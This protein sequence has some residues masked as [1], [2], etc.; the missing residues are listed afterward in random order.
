MYRWLETEPTDT[1]PSAVELSL[2]SVILGG[3]SKSLSAPGLR[4]GWLITHDT[5]LGERLKAAK[6]Y[7]TICGSAPS[8]ILAVAI[9][10]ARKGILA[11]NRER[12][13]ANVA[14]FDALVGRHPGLFGWTPPAAGP[15]AL[16]RLTAREGAAA[17]C[18][19]LVE[20]ASVMLLPSTVFDYGDS[21]VR[22]GLGRDAFDDGL[23]ALESWLASAE[24]VRTRRDKT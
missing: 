4:V 1:L 3:L 15:V 11:R 17:F 19:R 8:E 2:R 21:H 6:D 7:T 13:R 5:A 24:E 16:V 20:E 14:T 22:V 12:I 23:A 10:R 9:L 18:Q